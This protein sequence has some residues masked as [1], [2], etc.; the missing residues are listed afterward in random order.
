M[1]ELDTSIGDIHGLINDLEY[2]ILQKLENIIVEN[3]N[4]ICSI[5]DVVS[6]LDCI[7][8]MSLCVQEF[9]LTKPNLN[10]NNKLVIKNGRNLIQEL[11]VNTF[12]ANDTN[13]FENGRVHLITGP[14][15]SG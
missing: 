7:I 13:I 8:S 6:E 15:N 14:N 10:K 1:I 9:N 3:F 11:C 2:K 4:L 5:N 12:I